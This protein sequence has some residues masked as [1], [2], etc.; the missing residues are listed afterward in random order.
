MRHPLVERVDS[1]LA[2]S[3]L[4]IESQ[5]DKRPLKIATWGLASAAVFGAVTAGCVAV[6]A[7]AGAVVAV[8]AARRISADHRKG[9]SADSTEFDV[10][11]GG[12]AAATGRR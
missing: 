11:D 10:T 3:L 1:R 8:Q 6:A 12:N 5:I 4:Q 2:Q 9:L 7:A